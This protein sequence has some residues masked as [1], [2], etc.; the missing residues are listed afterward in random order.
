M[1]DADQDSG[2]DDSDAE[3]TAGFEDDEVLV[4]LVEKV[5]HLLKVNAGLDEK[6]NV[7]G[8][9][10][11]SFTNALKASSQQQ[12]P[13]VSTSATSSAAVSQQSSIGSSI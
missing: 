7:I 2:E 13:G 8:A 12:Y 4:A 6:V 1:G 10:L 9:V 3:S 11:L 5:D